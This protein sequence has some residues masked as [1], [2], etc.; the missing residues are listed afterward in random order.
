MF[1]HSLMAEQMFYLI[2]VDFKSCLV[3]WMADWSC[4][5]M[6]FS[7]LADSWGIN[8]NLKC[9]KDI[10]FINWSWINFG[11]MCDVVNS[12]CW[13]ETIVW[14]KYTFFCDWSREISWYDSMISIDIVVQKSIM[15]IIVLLIYYSH[16]FWNVHKL[17]FHQVTERMDWV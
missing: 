10:I 5:V 6:L 8:C 1:N 2:Y 11:L 7:L 17:S 14:M 16:L 13:F 15:I 3:P 9:E 12:A 4:Y